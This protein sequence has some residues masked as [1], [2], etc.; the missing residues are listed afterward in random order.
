MIL[1]KQKGCGGYWFVERDGKV[2]SFGWATS[3]GAE[4][5]ALREYP[6]ERVVVTTRTRFLYTVEKS[7][8]SGTT[9]RHINV[10]GE[11]EN[12]DWKS[13]SHMRRRFRDIV[14]RD[15]PLSWADP[16]GRIE[17]EVV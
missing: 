2:T 17:V 11:Y 4:G 7:L 9:Y 5:Y 6:G 13:Q 1:I 16:T 3:D 14:K 12:N 15:Y 8:P 10:L